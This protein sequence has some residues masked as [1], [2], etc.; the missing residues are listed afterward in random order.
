VVVVAGLLVTAG[1][2]FAFFS[3]TG[4][5]VGS[6]T[7]G[8]STALK[9]YGSTPA[10]GAGQGTLYPG[11]AVTFT[12]KADNPSKGIQRI[13][14]VTLT[15]IRACTGAGSVWTPSLN[16]GNGGCSGSG[17]EQ[18]TCETVSNINPS[19]TANFSMVDVPVNQDLA[20]NATS[21]PLGGQFTFGQL[22]MNNLSTNQDLCK[23]ASLYLILSS[24]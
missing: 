9:L 22:A 23:N 3:T 2:A 6:A 21:V 10:G 8:D 18:T 4:S 14:T 19:T 20:G 16:S 17:T 5:G 11:T 15:G 7:V 24:N 13:G 1:T 12:L